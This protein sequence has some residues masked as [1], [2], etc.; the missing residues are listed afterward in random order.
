MNNTI[1]DI[2]EFPSAQAEKLQQHLK[3]LDSQGKLKE[4][5]LSRYEGKLGLSNSLATYI[6]DNWETTGK[7]LYIEYTGIETYSDKHTI[8]SVGIKLNEIT[9]GSNKKLLWKCSTC[10]YEWVSQLN[11]RVGRGSGCPACSKNTYT[12]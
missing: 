10:G 8:A 5:F 6:K 7:K 3:Y 2:R 11:M 9:I 12:K 1:V 4:E